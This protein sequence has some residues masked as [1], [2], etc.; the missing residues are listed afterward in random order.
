MAEGM[1]SRLRTIEHKLG[2]TDEQARNALLSE[3]SQ[4][5]HQLR[6]RIDLL[7]LRVTGDPGLSGGMS[8]TPYAE[9]SM[10][11]VQNQRYR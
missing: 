2:I 11:E 10:A 9:Q 3:L 6:V 5:V 8:P 4:M 7:E 1:D